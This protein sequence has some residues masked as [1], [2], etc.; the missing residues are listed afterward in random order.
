M[1]GRH[2]VVTGGSRGIGAEVARTLAS[3]GA[4]VTLIGRD[5][6]ALEQ[7][8]QGLPGEGHRTVALD[9]ADPEA[10]P[11]AAA[12]L[13]AV[14]GLVTAAGVLA[15][16]GP[17]GTYDPRDFRR[18]LEVNVFGT[19]LAVHHCLPAIK[20][21]R[22]SIVTFSG[23][24]GT[25]PLPRYDA[26]AASKAAVIRLTENLAAALREEGVRV[27]CVAPGFVAT[28][29]HAATLQAGPA[30][31]GQEYFART[32]RQLAEG[33][34]PAS[35]AAELVALLLDSQPRFTGKVVSAQW[36]PWRDPEFRRRLEQ[37]AELGT[38]RRIDDH[39]FYAREP[40]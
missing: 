15:P 23:G 3:R 24:G 39:F 9:V 28:E 19:F 32:E 10:W 2:T 34:V 4:T 6:Q 30:R 12:E 31:S 27:N 5:A 18:T 33:G 14:H 29:M 25:S 26:Y 35:E 8:R 37:E 20:A 40:A 1:T 13:G 21:V 38:L 17:V 22:G 16:V 11:R 36:D 7:T